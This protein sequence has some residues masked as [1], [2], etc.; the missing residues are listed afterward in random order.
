MTKVL[1]YTGPVSEVYYLPHHAVVKESST[2]TKV[3]V[4]F[5]ASSKSTSG[6]SLNSLLD[7][8]HKLQQD[9]SSIILRWRRHRFVIS[10]DIEKMFRQIIVAPEDRDLQR[11][12]WRSSPSEPISEYQLNTVTYGTASASYLAVR[13]LVQL[14]RDEP[15]FCNATEPLLRDFYMDDLLTGADTLNET[16]AIYQDIIKLLAKGGFNIRKWTS[17]S[18]AMMKQIPDDLQETGDWLLN[19]ESTIR[20]LGVVWSPQRKNSRSYRST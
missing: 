5:N 17:N 11:I 6:L 16:I 9:L 3:R 7:P 13:T 18:K 20:T 2:T 14:A 8:G 19:P 12:I 4:V 10:G 15:S 1:P